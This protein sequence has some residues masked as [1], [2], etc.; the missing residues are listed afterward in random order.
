M[1]DR[2]GAPLVVER[3]A[4]IGK[5]NTAIRKD[6]KLIIRDAV[7]IQPPTSFW[8]EDFPEAYLFKMVPQKGKKNPQ[9]SFQLIVKGRK[10]SLENKGKRVRAKKSFTTPDRIKA[11]RTALGVA[12]MEV[13]PDLGEE[14]LLRLAEED[15]GR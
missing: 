13:S 9:E 11:L 3:G 7:K 6:R 10:L 12:R 2:E 4:T 8:L 5:L 1:P 14:G 15:I